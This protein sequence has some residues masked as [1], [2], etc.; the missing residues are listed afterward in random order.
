MTSFDLSLTIAKAG[1]KLKNEGTYLGI[2]WYLLNP[3]LTFLLL[4]LV[5][6]TRLGKNIPNYAS[7]VLLGIIIFNFFQQATTEATKV[8]RGNAGII[9]SINFP[10]EALVGAI[11]LKALFSHF[12]EITAM[13]IFLLFFKIP[14]INIIFYPIILV[15]LSIFIFGTTLI[16]SSLTVYFNDLN[17]IWAFISRLIWLGT[18]TFYA[19]GG[20]KRLLFINQFNPMYYFITISREIIIYAR[21]P[22]LSLILGAVGYSLLSLILGLIIFN[23]L[24]KKFAEMI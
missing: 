18:P 7:Y 4:F 12:F 10:H 16:L 5:F 8:I 2:F 24:K 21:C 11:A 13:S 6:S 3:L 15:F 20:Q 19:I 9:K 22:K 1:F 17:N 23:K 14:L